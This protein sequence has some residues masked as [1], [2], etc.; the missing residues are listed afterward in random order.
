M[1][2]YRERYSSIGLYESEVYRGIPEVLEILQQK[3][4]ALYVATSKPTV[5]AEQI[6]DHFNLKRYFKC[7]YGSELDGSLCDKTSLISHIVY[8]ESISASETIMIGDRKY[9]IIGA[10]H[11]GIN[12]FAVLWG[13]GTKEELEASGAHTFIKYPRELIPLFD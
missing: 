6:V 9:D 12:G 13:Y 1:G 8:A 10:K 3:G 7:I 11:N 5:F 2:F 4:H